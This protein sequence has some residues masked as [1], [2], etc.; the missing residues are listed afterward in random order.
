MGSENPIDVK[1]LVALK[2]ERIKGYIYVGQFL[3]FLMLSKGFCKIGLILILQSEEESERILEDHGC[4][5]SISL[6]HLMSY[7]RCLC[8]SRV[9]QP[10]TSSESARR[11]SFQQDQVS[12]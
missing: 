5:F 2:S 10:S 9:V 1:K 11:P 7:A 8:S 12:H 3:P 4:F 6:I